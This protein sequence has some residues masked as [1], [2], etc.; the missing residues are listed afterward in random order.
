MARKRAL[1]VNGVN[2][3]PEILLESKSLRKATAGDVAFESMIVYLYVLTLA[4]VN[5]VSSVWIWLAY[6]RSQRRENSFWQESQIICKC[7]PRDLLPDVR[8]RVALR[9]SSGTGGSGDQ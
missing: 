9:M 1:P 5:I 4:N 3:A 8:L 7:F 2:M 6:L